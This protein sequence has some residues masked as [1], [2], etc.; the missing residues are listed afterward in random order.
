MRMLAKAVQLWAW[1]SLCAVIALLVWLFAY[2]FVKGAGVITPS[3]LMDAP[4]GAVLGM[5]GGIFPAITGSLCFTATAVILGSI[6]AIAMAVFIVFYCENHLMERWMRLVIR[7]MSGVPS[8]VLGLFSYS[9]FVRRLGLGRCVLS[10]GAALALMIVPFIEVRAEK[11]FR[12]IPPA[13]LRASYNLGCSRAYT[14][15]RLV[16][17]MCAGELASGII[18]GACY[19]MG[20]TAPLMF[21]GGVAFAHTPGSVLEPAM[22]LPLH[23]YMLVEQGNPSLPQAYGTAFVMMAIILVSNISVTIY[24]QRYCRKWRR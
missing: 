3:F 6:P 22:A 8:I 13:I 11:I 23:L 15:R 19:A 14:I 21:T 12:E 17:P 24:T 18:L 2:V 7:C 5:E 1:I 10:A 9:F 16:L 4:K 20:A